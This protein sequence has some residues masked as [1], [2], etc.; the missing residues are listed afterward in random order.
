MEP[1]VIAVDLGGTKISGALFDREGAVLQREVLR[2]EHRQGREVGEQVA[3]LIHQLQEVAQGHGRP[4]A[5]VGIGVPGIYYAASGRVWAPNIPGW[6]DYPLREEI[7]AILGAGIRLHIDS[8]RACYILGERWKGA[9]A[10]CRDAIFLAVGTGIGAGIIVDGRLLRGHS[11]IGGA[12]GWLVLGPPELPGHPEGNF[13]QYASGE[14]LAKTA[15]YLHGYEYVAVRVPGRGMVP[16]PSTAE[17]FAAYDAGD[18]VAI[19]IVKVAISLWGKAAANLVSIFNPEKIIFG[20]GVFGPAA[21]LLP[22]IREEAERWAQPISMKQ[23]QLEVSA[24]GG[25]AG[26]YG[27]GYLAWEAE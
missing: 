24:L 13:E 9:A 10:G 27:A 23:V 21:D 2:R 25:D 19:H 15:A 18:P 26:L 12:V 3:V 16:E 8:D 14:G 20:G 7:V 6:E 1:T 22:L 4:V 5:A 11:D 17:L